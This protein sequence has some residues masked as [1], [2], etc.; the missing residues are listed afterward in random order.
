M[1]SSHETQMA[2][3][4]SHCASISASSEALATPG[5]NPRL[6]CAT[7]TGSSMQNSVPLITA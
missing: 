6:A 7:N 2:S 5:R 4:F 1:P 3:S